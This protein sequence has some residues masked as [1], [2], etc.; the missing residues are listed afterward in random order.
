MMHT[1]TISL[2]VLLLLGCGHRTPQKSSRTVVIGS[3]GYAA[4]ED[5]RITRNQF[6]GEVWGECYGSG[7]N[8]VF[9]VRYPTSLCVFK[10]TENVQS[11][12]V[13]AMASKHEV[14][15]QIMQDAKGGWEFPA[16]ANHWNWPAV[17]KVP[18]VTTMWSCKTE[19]G[20]NWLCANWTSSKE[21][22]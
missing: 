17:S 21:S 20:L 1:S 6:D 14:L 18:N 3:T 19:D 2:A 15:W 9:V 12:S 8:P 7:I 5:L 4:M 11:V 10:L 13:T 22:Q 16:P